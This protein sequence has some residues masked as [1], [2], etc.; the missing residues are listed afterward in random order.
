MLYTPHLHQIVGG[1]AFNATMDPETYDMPGLSTCTSCSFAEDMSNY[2]TAV[3]FFHHKNGS[4]HRV[5]QVGNGGP[6]GRLINDGG[7]DVYY[8]PSGRVTA[9]APVST[10]S[11]YRAKAGPSFRNRTWF[12][13]GYQLGLPYACR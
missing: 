2:W 9:F 7:L 12:T 8:I 5:K 10:L 11:I 3:M 6:Q 13:D 4:Y 1:N